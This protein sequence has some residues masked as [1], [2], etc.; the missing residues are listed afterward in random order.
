MQSYKFILVSFDLFVMIYGAGYSTRQI[1]PEMTIASTTSN[2]HVEVI[3]CPVPG[4]TLKGLSKYEKRTR[5]EWNSKN[6][7]VFYQLFIW[8]ERT[9]AIYDRKVHFVCPDYLLF[10]VA[11]A[12]PKTASELLT[13]QYPLP[14]LLGAK[15]EFFD[16]G[17][18][19]SSVPGKESWDLCW[20][21]LYLAT[22]RT[23]HFLTTVSSTRSH[24]G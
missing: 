22:N 8:R 21:G 15:V 16:E 11:S 6:V 3:V 18:K 23:I 13:L 17:E 4:V 24:F 12:L 14:G 5:S 19:E 10:E 9:A 20:C 1:N 2:G 7:Y